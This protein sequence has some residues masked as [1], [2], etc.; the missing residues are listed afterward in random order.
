MTKPQEKSVGEP[1]DPALVPDEVEEIPEV[2]PV[3]VPV[4]GKKPL[5]VKEPI[6]FKWKIV[7]RSGGVAVTLFKSTEREETDGQLERLAGDGYYTHL[8]IMEA[9]AK[10]VQPEA[11]REPR[12]APKPRET[13]VKS[14]P[15][16]GEP[17][18]MA[19]AGDAKRAPASRRPT[20]PKAGDKSTARQAKT[21]G[22]K[23]TSRK[24]AKKK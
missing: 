1:G 22:S 19:K 16:R 18:K 13:P 11:P 23:K 20:G 4:S 12:R 14:P 9:D 5:G 17:K 8:E 2:A 24:P 7:G 15:G 6:I 21:K 10:V 3:P